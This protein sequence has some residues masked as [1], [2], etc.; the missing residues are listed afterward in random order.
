MI[1]TQIPN[2]CTSREHLLIQ[3]TS[4]SFPRQKIHFADCWNLLAMMT[5]S[6]LPVYTRLQRPLQSAKAGRWT[7]T[8]GRRSPLKRLAA[9]RYKVTPP[10]AGR[11]LHPI[12]Q[13]LC[14][15]LPWSGWLLIQMT[16]GSIQGRL[17]PPLTALLK[18]ASTPP[19]FAALMASQKL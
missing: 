15:Y 16:A 10:A 11:L 12:Q 1:A 18:T 8:G 19:P 9:R 6:Q 4:I 13:P 2:Y 7:H 5:Q 14:N 3:K 17:H